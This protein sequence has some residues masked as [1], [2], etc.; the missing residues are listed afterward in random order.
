MKIKIEQISLPILEKKRI[1]LFV[2]RID[3]IHKYISGNKWYKLKYN[4]QEAKDKSEDTLLT[5]G[6]AYS[7]HIVATACI[8][9]E[10][11]LKSVGVIRGE[12]SFP[13]N[14]SLSI[15]L[16][17]G[18]RLK[19]I[20]RK[21]FRLKDQSGFI[22]NLQREFGSF[23]IIPEGGT[24][25]LGVK[26]A[27]GILDAQDIHDY[28]C[29]PVATGGTLSGIINS[30]SMSQKIIGFK[31]LKGQGVLYKDIKSFTNKNN[32]QII[33]DYLFGGYAKIDNKLITF[34]NNFFL[35]HDIGLDV[36]YTAKMM[37]GVLDLIQKDYFKSNSSILVI[38][39]GGLQAN[40]GMNNR[41]GLTL[42]I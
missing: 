27:E 6:G 17:N 23:Y 2:K 5:F 12:E 36:I 41:F 26:G 29:V 8:A 37:F 20:S 9:R 1:S 39:T 42:P 3:L 19:Y 13:L 11:G 38:H 33:E 35:Q 22:E 10:N 40:K 15:A 18:M 14:P 7:N 32:W 16:E 34:I 30:S 24:N 4:V 21:K 31:S 28:V 25:I